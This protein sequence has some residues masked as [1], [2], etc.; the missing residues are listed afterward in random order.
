L[1]NYR[2]NEQ[3]HVN[4]FISEP[5]TQKLPVRNSKTQIQMPKISVIIPCYN[6]GQY[7]DQA[8]DSVLAQ[9]F[10]DFEIIIVNDGSTDSFTVEKLNIYCKPK[11]RVIHTENQGLA[12]ARNNGFIQSKGEFIQFL[13]ADDILLPKKHELQLQIF[14]KE[15]V[16]VCYSNY[17]FY[18]INTNKLL[19]PHN[20]D[21]LT[22]APLNDFLFKW[23]RGLSIPIHAALFKRTIWTTLPFKPELRAKED[24]LMWTELA[25]DNRK[26]HFLNEEL[27]YYRFHNSNM[28]KNDVEMY[29]WFFRTMNIIYI[30]IPLEIKESFLKKSILHIVNQVDKNLKCQYQSQIA[31]LK[32]L[33]FENEQRYWNLQQSSEYKFGSIVF[34]ILKKIKNRVFK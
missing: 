28:C 12:A 13:D 23:E 27:V 33:N 20:L 8:V 3:Q 11:T 5:N 34:S 26:F 22:N 17:R 16:D 4:R 2:I 29:Y 32:E 24:W 21:F 15:E 9:T 31:K 10:Q 7:V 30:L 6:Q 14:E 1:G 25:I 19:P 18:D